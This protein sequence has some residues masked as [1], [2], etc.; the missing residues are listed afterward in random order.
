MPMR[1]EDHRGSREK[2]RESPKALMNVLIRHVVG[3]A[4]TDC[5]NNPRSSTNNTAEDFDIRA[6]LVS[7]FVVSV[8]NVWFLVTAGHIFQQIGE[9]L[10][11][12]RRIFKSRL[13]DGLTSTMKDPIPFD[14]DLSSV[15]YID[16]DGYDYGLIPLHSFF[17]R[18][19]IH[20]G[21]RPLTEKHWTD[22]H[23]PVDEY[24][25][26]GFPSQGQIITVTSNVDGGKI[27]VDYGSPLLPIQ[28]V[29]IPPD[30]LKTPNDRFYA[31]VPI[32]TG[33][34]GHEETKLTD[35]SGMSG[36]PIFAVN[37]VGQN[38]LSHWIIA[39]QSSWLPESRI[40]AACFIRPLIDGITKGLD[41]HRP[42]LKKHVV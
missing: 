39:V 15:W 42:D 25:L 22:T 32:T 36:G 23:D 41:Q 8:R 21:I 26:L 16:R 14:L 38:K 31:K 10:Q 27:H 34:P 20:G 19:L 11:S 17:A 18:P 1:Q 7:T 29:I 24:Y 2:E 40:L 6:L 37:R 33:K 3:L 30:K 28:R 5:L 4:V 9:R 12:G 13:L 35:I